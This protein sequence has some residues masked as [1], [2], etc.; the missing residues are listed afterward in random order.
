MSKRRKIKWDGFETKSNNITLQNLC[1]NIIIKTIHVDKR[2]FVYP[3]YLIDILIDFNKFY[4]I[5]CSNRL[6]KCLIYKEKWSLVPDARIIEYD[7]VCINCVINEQ[8]LKNAL[9]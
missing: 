6:P 2:S 7:R 3:Q 8:L 9:G 4:C 5:K 1:I